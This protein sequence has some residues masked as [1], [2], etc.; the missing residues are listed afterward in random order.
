VLVDKLKT[1]KGIKIDQTIVKGANHFFENNVDELRRAS[2]PLTIAAIS[3]GDWNSGMLGGAVAVCSMASPTSSTSCS[4]L[5]RRTMTSTSPS[6]MRS[7]GS[8]SPASSRR[9]ISPTVRFMSAG[10]AVIG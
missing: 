5:T 8:I 2:H 7:P 10:A 1:Q 6:G 9:R 4:S 3:F